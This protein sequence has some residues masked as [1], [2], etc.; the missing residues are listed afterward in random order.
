[1]GR[2][3]SIYDKK[4]GWESFTDLYEKINEIREILFD[5]TN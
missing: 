4:T 5:D 3:K 1:V 2:P